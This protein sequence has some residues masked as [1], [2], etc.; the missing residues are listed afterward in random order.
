M[1]LIIRSSSGRYYV[2]LSKAA[3]IYV[4]RNP[5]GDGGFGLKIFAGMTD[6]F[7]PIK[8]PLD[9]SD[10]SF[11]YDPKDPEEA[12]AVRELQ[13]ALALAGGLPVEPDEPEEKPTARIKRVR[14]DK[15][16]YDACAVLKTE[17]GFTNKQIAEKTGI[18]LNT[19]INKFTE[20][21]V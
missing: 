20:R 13:E 17:L 10:Y 8:I 12:G 19:I 3:R 16:V 14:R 9:F 1:K 21:G 15:S 7:T 6:D 2:D 18:P 11:I 5:D 4:Y